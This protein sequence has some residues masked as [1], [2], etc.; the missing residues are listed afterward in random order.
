MEDPGNTHKLY[1]KHMV[2][3]RCIMKVRQILESLQIPYIEVKL[4]EVILS[5]SKENYDLDAL[6]QELQKVGFSL[7]ENQQVKLVEEIKHLVIDII[8]NAEQYRQPYNVSAYLADR[9]NKNYR[10]L[11][12][13]FSVQ[14]NITIEKYIILQK[15]EYVK[16][17]L[18]YDELSLSEIADKLK[19]SSISHLSNQFKQVT[20][21]SPSQFKNM[22]LKDR[23]SID[24]I[25]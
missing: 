12:Y 2:C 23:R 7:I 15:I 22:Q 21:L 5:E 14:E 1:I 8:R 6:Q 18:I 20:G 19:Y 3:P 24:E 25:S 4:G 10:Y 16:E 13:I 9:L 17:L 11:S